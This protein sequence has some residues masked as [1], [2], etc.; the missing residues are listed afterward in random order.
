MKAF[1]H[2]RYGFGI[3]E[4]QCDKSGNVCGEGRWHC[5]EP[6]E[7]RDDWKGVII[8]GCF[9]GNEPEGF[10]KIQKHILSL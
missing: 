5:T 10:R 4:G 3:Y 6:V 9:K 1:K 7:G 2:P 8:E